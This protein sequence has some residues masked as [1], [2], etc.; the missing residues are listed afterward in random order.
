MVNREAVKLQLLQ[1]IINLPEA[2]L[3]QVR[4]FIATLAD[5]DQ[6]LAVDGTQ[7]PEVKSKSEFQEPELPWDQDPLLKLIGLV[8]DGALP[9][10]SAEI[11]ALLYGKNSL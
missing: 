3:P 4:D 10:T 8:D 5:D 6:E 9:S 1:Q 7:H 2:L 11:D